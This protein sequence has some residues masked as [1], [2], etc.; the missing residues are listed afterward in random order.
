MSK[1]TELKKK[2]QTNLVTLKIKHSNAPLHH[3]KIGIQK[4]MTHNPSVARE[5]SN[6]TVIKQFVI[7]KIRVIFFF[8]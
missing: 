5:T 4:T 8:F 2:K 6:F 7:I 1:L 3:E